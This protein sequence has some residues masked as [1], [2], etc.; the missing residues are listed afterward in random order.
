MTLNAM[1][2]ETGGKKKGIKI[3]FS[4]SLEM[5]LS[6]F[7]QYRAGISATTKAVAADRKA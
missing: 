6:F 2:I 4:S 5:I 7:A 3:E 1:T